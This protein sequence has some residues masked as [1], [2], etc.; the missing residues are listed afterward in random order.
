[1]GQA[2]VAN[3]STVAVFTVPAGLCNVTFWNVAAGTVYLGTSSAATTVNNGLQCHS[4]PTSFFSYVS[5]KGATFW[6][7]NTSGSSAAVN[8]IIATAQ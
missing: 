3:N 5:S 7:V 4:I 6:G 8:Y 1:M 2:A